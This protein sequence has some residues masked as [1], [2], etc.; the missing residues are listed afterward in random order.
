M[1]RR[2]D[3][4]HAGGLM[5]DVQRL[6]ETLLY[7]GY[8]LW[9]YRRSTTK[10]QQRWTIG[11]VYPRAYSD[12]GGGTDR[13]WVQAECLVRGAEP[14]VTVTIRFLQ[15]VARQV[16]RL[17]ADGGLTYVD[18]LQVGDARFVAWEEAREHAVRIEPRDLATLA[19]PH[20]VPVHIP[21]GSD[22]EP[23]LA[24]DGTEVGALVRRWEALD[25]LVDVA[26]APVQPEVFRLTVRFE[27]TSAWEGTERTG[28]LARTFV[29]AHAILE[30]DGGEFVSLLDPPGELA[31]ASA[32]CEN[33]GVWPVLAG[34][35]GTARTMLASPIILYDYPRLA[36]ESPGDLFDGTEIDQL[37]I[38]SI[39]GLTDEEKEEMR[40]AD[41]RAR[42]I[43]ERTERLTASDFARLH[44]AIREFQ[45]LRPE[46]DVSPAFAALEAPAPESVRIGGVEVRPG[47]RVRLRPR[48]GGDVFDLALAGRI[49]IVESIE[50]DYEERIH[51]AVTIE[52]DPGRHLAEAGVLGHQ[53]YF[54]LDEVEPLGPEEGPP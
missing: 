45:M 20:R 16:G 11:G 6:A 28:A 7:E 40:A 35:P 32:A 2:H 49:A 3:A 15:V 8:I 22:R 43:L 42:E 41:P 36:P 10:N 53:F 51:L 23:L 13:W 37:L 4:C 18:E 50:Q 19:A 12:A 25:G 21:A 54:G 1:R 44:G 24:A 47:S 29:A 38:L 46:P 34:E 31:A 17:E 14:R 39:L 5:D 33:A 26:A 30:A 48:S 27:N 9:P 52:D